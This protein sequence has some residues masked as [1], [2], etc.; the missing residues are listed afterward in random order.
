MAYK[1]LT[2]HELKN[3]N[4]GIYKQIVWGYKI[5]KTIYNHRG[6]IM[7]GGTN[8]RKRAEKENY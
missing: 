1:K 5:G 8:G 7:Q 4:G 6:E 2:Q 3:N